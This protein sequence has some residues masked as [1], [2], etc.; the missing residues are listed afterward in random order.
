MGQITPDERDKRDAYLKLFE[1]K[2]HE[3]QELL[4]N[5]LKAF[6]IF[7]GITSVLIKFALDQYHIWMGTDQGE[8]Y[9]SADS[10]A[11]WTAQGAAAGDNI[12]YI[13]FMNEYFGVAV[14]G[15][16]G[17]SHVL[18]YTTD[19]GGHWNAVTFTG[20]GAT[21]M[22]NTVEIIN[23]QSWLVGFENGTIYKTWDQGNN[24][25]LLPQPA[26]AGLTAWGDIND[27]MKVDECC[28][29]ACA[30]ATVSGNSKGIIMRTVNGGYDWE[31]WAT[32]DGDGTY[33]MQAIHACHYN[34]AVACGDTETTTMVYDVS[35]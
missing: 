12:R 5:F 7:L 8:I 35:D 32:A 29:W 20:P 23:E 11:T 21:V 28:I 13:R 3:S 18:L 17:A 27:M 34:R 31:V 10:G 15:S 24:W 26:Y 30:E 22:A 6:I 4:G 19:G 9:F 25:T 1:I 16:T 2:H 14:G 33:G